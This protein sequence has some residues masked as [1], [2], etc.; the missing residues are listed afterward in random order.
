MLL[1]HLDT[2]CALEDQ[3]VRRLTESL[4]RYPLRDDFDAAHN[5]AYTRAE[6][7]ASLLRRECD[8]RALRR[9][10][11]HEQHRADRQLQRDTVL[12]AT[13]FALLYQR[14]ARRA[15]LERASYRDT[16]EREVADRLGARDTQGLTA[17]TLDDVLR[18]AMYDVALQLDTAVLVA[19]APKHA[20]VDQWYG[21][22]LDDYMSKGR[23]YC[24]DSPERWRMQAHRVYQHRRIAH[25]LGAA[26]YP[27]SH[28]RRHVAGQLR[29]QLRQ[30]NG[31]E[32]PVATSLSEGQLGETL[33]AAWTERAQGSFAQ[34]REEAMRAHRSH[35]RK[36]RTRTHAMARQVCQ[37]V[38]GR[39]RDKSTAHALAR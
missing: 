28:D 23:S 38:R 9:L 13:H 8:S 16:L 31:L 10:L 32:R 19:H 34:A 18:D 37:H 22:A 2:K 3:L 29:L 6:D 12:C 24:S 4:S 11:F 35:T 7:L 27:T 33:R 1:D 26:G 5:L 14:E 17:E 15:R 25:G 30:S 21:D 39:S 20:A 36:L